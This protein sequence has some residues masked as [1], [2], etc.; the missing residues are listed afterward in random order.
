M[1]HSILK[2]WVMILLSS[3]Y[4]REGFATRICDQMSDMTLYKVRNCRYAHYLNIQLVVWPLVFTDSTCID[5]SL[6]TDH[7]NFIS[8]NHTFI[9]TLYTI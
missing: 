6:Q 4:T 3:T 9:T 7:I 1:D 2:R 5:L 8:A